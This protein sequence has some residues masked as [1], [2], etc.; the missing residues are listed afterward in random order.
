MSKLIDNTEQVIHVITILIK[1]NKELDHLIVSL[2]N[3]FG[4]SRTIIVK[5]GK[6]LV[7]EI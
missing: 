3:K 6:T 2:F 1:N 4:S 5:E 7:H